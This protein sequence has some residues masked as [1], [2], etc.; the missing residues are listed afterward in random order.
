MDDDG[1]PNDPETRVGI[2][3]KILERAAQFGIP[4]TDIGIAP[5]VLIVGADGTAGRVTLDTIQLVRREFGVNIN[6]G[7]SNVSF[8]FPDR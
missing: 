3:G 4:D 1:I 7:A 6:L 5:L 2:A 8:G